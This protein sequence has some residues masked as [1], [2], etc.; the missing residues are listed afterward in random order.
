MK[1]VIKIFSALA[2]LALF[3]G[4]DDVTT[5]R[6]SKRDNT[7]T[8]PTSSRRTTATNTSS[9]KTTTQDGD[10]FTLTVAVD[11]SADTSSLRNT[12]KVFNKTANKELHNG[13]AYNEDDELV[14]TVFNCASDVKLHIVCGTYEIFP[15]FGYEKL[16]GSDVSVGQEE[17]A[18]LAYSNARVELL[19]DDGTEPI[20][21]CK[22]NITP[23]IYCM[24]ILTCLVT[25]LKFELPAYL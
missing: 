25:D 15:W 12:V 2:M 19:V 14:V 3:A 18:F 23:F 17:V 13:D 4:C 6:T 7:T 10:S 22:Y 20:E 1:K 24:V 5:K 9:K 21:Y 8:N 11:P 16:E